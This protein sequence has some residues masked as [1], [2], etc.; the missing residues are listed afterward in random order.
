MEEYYLMWLS[1]IEGIG[2]KRIR[3]LLACFQKAEA[4]W[5]AQREQLLSVKGI[6]EKTVDAILCSRD[7][8]KLERWIE[9]LEEKEIQFY[10][11]LHPQ[12]PSLLKEI[13]NPPIGIYVKGALPEDD[14]D[15]VSLVGARRCSRYGAGVTYRIAQDL[16]RANIV[17]V[18]GMAKGIDTMAHK[19]A[20]DGSGQTIAVLGCGVDICYPA[21]NKELME[22]ITKNGCLISEY[23]PGTE[24]NPHHF[25]NRN[26]IISGLS[27]ILVV[28]EA[29]KRSG[30]L[31]TADLALESGRDVFVVPGNVTSA[32]SEG[33]NN[34]IK[35]GCPVITESNDILLELG[36]IYKEEERQTFSKQMAEK[37]TPEEREIYDEI[38]DKEPVLA[39]TICRKLHKNI[40]E[41]QYILSLL[42]IAGYIRRV[43]Q[44]G[45]I[46]EG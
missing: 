10:S 21:E 19:G 35:Q 7:E 31:I 12:Y 14:I 4:V 42:E 16:G 6:P 25:P 27:K 32:L 39:E 18:S 15:K 22:Q 5:N 1:R 38:R 20:M 33:T 44:S 23:P 36:I 24:P 13:Y 8:E 3:V 17:V 43:P 40:Q 29:G 41:V 9:E 34:L 26:R 37:L 46:R 30:T 28:V 11:F 2:I 45:Y